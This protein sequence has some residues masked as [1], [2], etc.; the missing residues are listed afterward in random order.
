VPSKYKIKPKQ[1][2]TGILI[3]QHVICF[4]KY[5]VLQYACSKDHVIIFYESAFLC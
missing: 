1:L 2:F 4:N 3:I 5:R